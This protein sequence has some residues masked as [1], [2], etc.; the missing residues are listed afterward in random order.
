MIFYSAVPLFEKPLRVGKGASARDEAVEHGKHALPM[1]A[2]P[3]DTS[4]DFAVGEP[5][6]AVEDWRWHALL[7]Q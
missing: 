3:E 7:H 2:F 6:V 1:P 5:L 4:A